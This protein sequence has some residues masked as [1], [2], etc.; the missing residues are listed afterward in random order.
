MSIQVT[1]NNSE[2]YILSC[3]LQHLPHAAEVKL[4]EEYG[5]IAPLYNKLVSAQETGTV[6][7]L[8]TARH[9]GDMDAL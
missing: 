8:S 3:A 4:A 1:L 5:V 6:Y 7:D 9:G 2:L